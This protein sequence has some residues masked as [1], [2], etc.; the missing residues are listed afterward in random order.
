MLAEPD[1]P[2]YHTTQAQVVVIDTADNKAE[3]CVAGGT[4]DTR[5]ARIQQCSF[6]IPVP[7]N[8]ETVFTHFWQG[9][10]AERHIR[11]FEYRDSAE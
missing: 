5:N 7:A 10:W 3:I 9:G 6:T 11:R 4:V 8:L 2:R 1:K